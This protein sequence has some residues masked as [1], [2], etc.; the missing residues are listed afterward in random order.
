MFSKLLSVAGYL[1][2]ALFATNTY[3]QF[4]GC[5]SVDAGPNQTLTCSQTCATL[6]ATPFNAGA[7]TSYGVSSI[8][9]NPPIA[10]NQAGGTGVSVNV[11]DVWS[12]QVTL[13]FTFCYYGQSYNTCKIGSNG[14]IKFGTWAST[15]QP[16]SFTASCPSTNLVNAG[17]V[18]GVYHDIDPS[19]CG[20][21]NYYILGSAPC[22]IFVVSYDQICQFSCNAK[23]SRHMMVLY[24]TTNV[25]DVYVELKQTC[26]GWN[27][28]RA[29][30]GIQNP[31]GTL[32]ITAPNRNA[33]PTWTVNTPEAWRFTPAGA[34]IYTVEWFNGTTS[35]GV[36][37]SVSVCPTVAT[38]YTAVATYT[39]CD[40]SIVTA[41]DNV[42]VTPNASAPTGIETNNTFSSCT[43]PTGSTTVQG[44]G[45]A[46]GYTYSINGGSS[47]QSS[48]T[49]NNLAPGSYTVTIL[50]ANG[51]QGTLPITIT[52]ASNPSGTEILNQPTG[53][54]TPSGQTTV[55]GSG[56]SGSY[57]YSIDGGSS[58]Q[59]SGNFLG[60]LAGSYSIIVLD[61]GGCQGTVPVT[62]STAPNPS[63]TEIANQVTGCS[64]PTGQT[65][66]QGSGGSG[67]YTYSING[68]STFQSLGNFSTLSA[69]SYSVIVQD[70]N[71]CQGT[72]PITIGTAPAVN[73]S[74][75]S[76][77][78]PLCNNATNGS[79]QVAASA[80]TLNYS[81]SI[82]SGIGQSSGLFS[83]LGAGTYTLAV[84]D[85]QGCTATQSISLTNPSI[86]TFSVSGTTPSSCTAAN[87]TLTVTPAIGGAGGFQY[88]INNG[89]TFQSSN[90]FTGLAAGS[91]TVI[92][93]DANGCQSTTTGTV[94][95]TN[96][97]T[98]TI[99]AQTPVSCYGGSNGTVTVSGNGTV[100]PYAYAIDNGTPQ[101]SGTFPNL[102]AGSHI[103]TIGDINGCTTTVNVTITQPTQLTVTTNNSTSACIGA[104]ANLTAAGSGG[105]IGSG[106]TYSW[107]NGAGNNA[108]ATVSP[109]A[110]TTY[111]VTVTDANNCQATGQVLV[112]I[113]PLPIIT[114]GANQTICLGQPVTLNGAGGN[115]Y[116]WTN[117]VQNGVAFTPTSLGVNTYTV[118]GTDGNGC[119]NTATV[120]VT[121]VPVPIAGIS[122]TTAT[123]GYPGLIVDFSNSSQFATSYLFDFNNGF[124]ATSTNVAEHETSTFT[125]P[126]SYTVVLTAS[127]GICQDT[128][129]LAVIVL[130]YAP[131]VVSVPNVFTPDGDGTN[132]EFI[133][134][135]QFGISIEVIIVNRWDNVMCEIKDL[136]KGWDGTVNGTPANEGVYFAKYVVHGLDGTTQTGQTYIE[137][138]RK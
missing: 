83:N 21:I 35:L 119:Q 41:T 32:G 54:S 9:H 60:L 14:S 45:G 68:G 29:I 31:A 2:L 49:F 96:A 10:Y 67:S 75:V 107:N 92:A 120:T 132:D 118:T 86:I 117:S 27:G 98:G 63:G 97:L 82:N 99:T 22:R 70:G 124:T 71:G 85:A 43:A 33:S 114:A 138:F 4:P 102:T 64:G 46:G 5:P 90:N 30:L 66:V 25:I 17:D 81:Y 55:Q 93:Q 8:P 73:L 129:Q 19:V 94:T 74:P 16:W 111:T 1:M 108:N 36:S 50:D 123:T 42:L 128:A 48:G 121:I 3:A 100:A 38:T 110:T 137:L 57:T 84:V 89:S 109:T 134:S 133:I 20:D 7:T 51:C 24:E 65:T 113:N 39:A 130:P 53:C 127:N 95:S 61:G 62:I 80:G 115:Q 72:V 87:G 37:N 18:F 34:P 77:V 47:Y 88:S 69:G 28:G 78:N 136:N 52:T 76:S 13:P 126:G 135:V 12:A 40:G 59:S 125:L 116:T 6:T 131:L 26:T 105:T 103:V 56:G 44:S 91:Y 58:F 23:I 106:Y 11:D 112:T 104:S 15:T 79:I 122:A 101:V